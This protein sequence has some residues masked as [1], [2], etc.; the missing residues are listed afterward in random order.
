MLLW[1]H[2]KEKDIYVIL[3]QYAIMGLF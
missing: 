3:N 1:G 2:F